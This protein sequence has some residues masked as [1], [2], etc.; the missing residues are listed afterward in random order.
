MNHAR[1]AW[2]PASVGPQ[3]CRRC[4][5]SHPMQVAK[6][7]RYGVTWG[8]GRHH[9]PTPP[10]TLYLIARQPEPSSAPPDASPAR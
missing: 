10:F 1:F 7:T 8:L 9:C 3:V 4:G 5:E 2:T 6:R